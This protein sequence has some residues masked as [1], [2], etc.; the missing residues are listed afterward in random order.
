[1]DSGSFIGSRVL[2]ESQEGRNE[3]GFF[4]SV[5]FF[6][7]RLHLFN[8]LSQAFGCGIV[9]DNRGVRSV[10]GFLLIL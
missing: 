7:G 3:D 4:H 1:M 5:I 9:W 8:E 2:S 6:K 10:G